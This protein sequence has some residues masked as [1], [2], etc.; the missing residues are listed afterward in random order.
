MG[1]LGGQI[2]VESTEGLGSTF[3]FTAKLSAA[4]ARD[5]EK[6]L[7]GRKIALID[8]HLGR[9]RASCELLQILGAEVVALD[10]RAQEAPNESF[11]LGFVHEDV[12]EHWKDKLSTEQTPWLV[13]SRQLSPAADSLLSG[14]VRTPLRRIRVSD[15]SQK[16][17]VVPF[18]PRKESHPAL[19]GAGKKV[20]LVDDNRVNQMVGAQLV[21]MLG[22][23]VHIVANGAEALEVIG[24]EYFD[25][26]LMDCQM[27]V[28]DGFEATQSIRKLSS[29]ARLI[30]IIAMTANAMEGDREKCLAAGMDDYLTKPVDQKRLAK[31]LL[32]HQ[33]LRPTTS[34]SAPIPE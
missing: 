29:E 33:N 22:Y 24:Q 28:M 15:I 19:Q 2:G 7:A 4:Q 25:L 13:L 9:N 21:K 31:V 30:P 11:D 1:L 8:P 17:L 3:W 32:R 12:L 10:P 34:E 23:Q 18:N 27:P 16:Y 20:L 6:L 5:K 14:Q 26:V